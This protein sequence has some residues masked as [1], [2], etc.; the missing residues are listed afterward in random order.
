MTVINPFDYFFN[1]IF[2]AKSE[3]IPSVSLISLDV[4][5]LVLE[6]DVCKGAFKTFNTVLINESTI[7]FVVY[8]Q[9]NMRMIRFVVEGSV[10]LKGRRPYLKIFGKFISVSS[11][12]IPPAF[13]GFES[14]AFSVFSFYRD[15]YRPD[16]SFEVIEFIRHSI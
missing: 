6:D 3:F 1:L 10:P 9:M 13:T 2:S 16:C 14:E 5:H 4:Q 8:D 12:H 7:L 15:N 11:Y